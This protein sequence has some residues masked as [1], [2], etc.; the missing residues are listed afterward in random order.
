[1]VISLPETYNRPL[2]ASMD[3]AE[4]KFSK[5]SKAAKITSECENMI[6]KVPKNFKYQ[7]LLS[8]I[9]GSPRRNLLRGYVRI[10]ETGRFRIFFTC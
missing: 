8:F 2:M 1:M 6:E 3:E 7:R 9:Q 10:R 4:D 5:K